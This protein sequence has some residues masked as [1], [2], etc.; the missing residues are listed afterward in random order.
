[1]LAEISNIL[2]LLIAIGGLIFPQYSPLLLSLKDFEGKI[3][4]KETQLQNQFSLRLGRFFADLHTSMNV[5][6]EGDEI[7]SIFIA[8][9]KEHWAQIF[10]L[11]DLRNKYMFWCYIPTYA[12]L[13]LL[14]AIVATKI[15]NLFKI[16]PPQILETFVWV[17]LAL[18]IIS[19]CYC[20]KKLKSLCDQ[21]EEIK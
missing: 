3:L 21:L 19:F 13:C 5:P 16:L 7:Y 14:I 17:V 12:S 18:V 6:P 2:T 11:A 4:L 9:E 10:S 8:E 1:M 20:Y 15:G